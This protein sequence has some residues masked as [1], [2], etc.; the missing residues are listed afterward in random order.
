LSNKDDVNISVLNWGPNENVIKLR[1]PL[2]TIRTLLR[3]P[4]FR[5]KHKNIKNNFTEFYVPHITWSSLFRKGNYDAFISKALRTVD[6]IIVKKGRIDIIHAHVA[7]PAGYIACKILQKTGIPFIITEHSGPFPFNEYKTKTGLRKIISE[8]LNKANKIFAVSN[9]LAQ[10][11]KA[12]TGKSLIVIPNSVNT[13]L[14]KPPQVQT[15][16]THP[17]IFVLSHINEAKG[18][19]ELLTALQ[20]IDRKNIDF[21][22]RIGGSGK[23]LKHYQ[24]QAGLLGLNRSIEWLGFLNREE[25]LAE[26]QNCDFGVMPSRLESLSMVILET[27]ACGKP[28]VATDCGGPRDLVTAATGILTK[29]NDYLSLA[30]GIEQMIKTYCSYDSENIRNHCLDNYSDSVIT[31]KLLDIYNQVIEK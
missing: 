24:K 6:D 10:S 3:Y 5:E 25:A 17:R 21:S 13:D 8:P 31:N 20:V 14:F 26:Y 16:N 27:M 7:F 23:D 4:S 9:W 18:I 29:P 11:I 19:G 28:I 2:E 12:Y 22:V 1:N 15:H 30:D